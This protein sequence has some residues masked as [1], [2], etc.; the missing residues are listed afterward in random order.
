[1]SPFLAARAPLA[2][3]IIKLIYATKV[4]EVVILQEAEL[5]PNFRQRPRPS[6]QPSATKRVVQRFRPFTKALLPHYAPF[7]HARCRTESP[8]Q[9]F[10][11]Y[12]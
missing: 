8:G 2:L 12:N 11:W 7:G 4:I 9:I 1:M 3:T 10:G 5:T 6:D